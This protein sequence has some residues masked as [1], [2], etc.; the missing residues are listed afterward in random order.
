MGTNQPRAARATLGVLDLVRTLERLI[1]AP[2]HLGNAVRRVEALIGVHLPR[3]VV[4]RGHLPTGQVDGLQSRAHLLH[5]LVAGER[6]QR[7]D[8]ALRVQKLPQP[9]RTLLGQRVGDAQRATQ[10]LDIGVRIRTHDAGEA[11][12]HAGPRGGS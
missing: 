10:A 3:R 7:V 5:G 12:G 6:P 11:L 8:V 4:V 2:H 9:L 1:D